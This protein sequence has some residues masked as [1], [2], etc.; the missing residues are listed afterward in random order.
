MESRL[1]GK[2]QKNGTG[3]GSDEAL[4][5][6]LENRLSRVEKYLNCETIKGHKMKRA[7]VLQTLLVVKKT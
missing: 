7:N 2:V 4:S 5:A 3:W 6:Q 1:L